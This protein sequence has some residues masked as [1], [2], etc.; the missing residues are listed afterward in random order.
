MAPNNSFSWH[1]CGAYKT[2]TM[3]NMA[4]QWNTLN[5]RTWMNLEAQVLFWG[6]AAIKS[7]HVEAYNR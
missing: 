4:A 6:I 1:A 2:F 3:A 5:Q 7:G